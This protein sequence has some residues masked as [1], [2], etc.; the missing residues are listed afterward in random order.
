MNKVVDLSV[1]DMKLVH[2]IIQYLSNKKNGIDVFLEA[3]KP[4]LF[5]LT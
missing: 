5:V 3:I 2:Q 1:N 4:N